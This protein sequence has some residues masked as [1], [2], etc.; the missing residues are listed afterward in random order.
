M[1][2]LI[3]KILLIFI[4]LIVV[5]LAAN[6]N[7]FEVSE[8]NQDV[9]NQYL[10]YNGIKPIK[11]KNGALSWDIFTNMNEVLVKEKNP[12]DDFDQYYKPIYTDEIKK[13]NGQKI[14]LYGFIFPLS[15]GTEQTNFLFGAFPLSCPYH[16]HVSPK[17]TVEVITKTP[18][19]FSLDPVLIEGTL[20]LSFNQ[21]TQIFYY[22]KDA[23]VSK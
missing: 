21:D 2:S 11:A 19:K 10:N 5:F 17:M 3:K 18:I 22:L 23:Q 15:E 13:L 9:E 7:A 12:Q 14:K 16:Y 8:L 4:A 1:R 6:S 20:D